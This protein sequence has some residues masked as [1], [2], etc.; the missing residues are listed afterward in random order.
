[1]DKFF[2]MDRTKLT[3]LVIFATWMCVWLWL[4]RKKSLSLPAAVPASPAGESQI[5]PYSAAPTCGAHVGGCGGTSELLPI[6]EPTFNLREICIQCVLLE[7][8]L[9]SPQRRCNDCVKKHFLTI[10]GLADEAISLDVKGELRPAL[11]Q[12]PNRVR[13]I[14]EMWVSGADPCEVAQEIRKIRKPLMHMSF[15]IPG[16]RL[17]SPR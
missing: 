15:T 7:H 17:S 5:V 13:Q 6:M 4:R 14:Q 10:E 2:V 16:K 12:L 11:L 3:V 8:H 9:N 1:M